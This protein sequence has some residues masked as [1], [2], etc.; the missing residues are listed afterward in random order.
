MTNRE[1]LVNTLHF[2]PVDRLPRIEWA[3]WWTQTIERWKGEDLPFELPYEKISDYWGLDGLKQIWCAPRSSGCPTP[4]FHGSGI[5]ETEKDYEE[6][7]PYLFPKEPI[8]KYVEQLKKWKP[9]HDRGEISI[10]LSF[11]GF[12][13]FPRTLFG[14]ENH[15]YAFYDYP[16][17][18]HRMNQEESD[19]ILTCIEELC[20]V[21]TPD[22]MTFAEDMSYNN[23]PM[24]SKKAFDEF[25]KPYYLK[26][27]PIIKEK[28]IIP[29]VDTDGDVTKLIPWL[30]E[31]G[32]EGILPLERQAGV[33]VA[34]I[35]R[36]YPDFRLIG[37]YDKTIMHKGEAAMRQEFERLLH[38]MRTGGFI[39]SVDHQTPPDV[40][41]ENYRVY[42]KLLKEYTEKGAISG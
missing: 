19:Y 38:V 17:L 27:V 13:W 34:E 24:L 36:M 29:M 6:L 35:R 15:L 12:F 16:E 2:R 8:K 37:A 33:D 42:L 18:M 22:F 9:L 7:H 41:T 31:V 40:S 26:T 39:P 3:S 32:I 10:W 21:L 20:Q 1:R 4:R 23:G 11:D 14:I 25:L 30:R 5:M 28:G